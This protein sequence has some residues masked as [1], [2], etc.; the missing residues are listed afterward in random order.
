MVCEE[1]VISEVS[2]FYQAVRFTFLF[3]IRSTFAA[4]F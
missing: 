2:P 3:I 4:I 1:A